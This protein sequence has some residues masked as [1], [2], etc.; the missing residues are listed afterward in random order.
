MGG[1]LW[2]LPG[3][4][5]DFAHTEGGSWSRRTIRLVSSESAPVRSATEQIKDVEG[6]RD[7]PGWLFWLP[8]SDSRI[9]SPFREK[10]IPAYFSTKFGPGECTE[11]EELRRKGGHL[12]EGLGKRDQ[13]QRRD[14]FEVY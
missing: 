8:L 3:A 9:T 5:E 6:S 13:V 1:V 11:A 7:S 10:E 12:L 14:P 2:I 4:V